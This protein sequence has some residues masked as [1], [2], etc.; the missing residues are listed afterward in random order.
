MIKTTLALFAIGTLFMIKTF[1]IVVD[2]YVLSRT[3]V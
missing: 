2:E 1:A 3:K